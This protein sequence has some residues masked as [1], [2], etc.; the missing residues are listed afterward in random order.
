MTKDVIAL[1][2]K[3]PDP[4]A[5]LMSLYAGGPDLQAEALHAGAV[6]QLGTPAGRPLLTV[7]SPLLVHVPGEAARLLGEGADLPEAPLWWTEAR[8]TTNVPEAERLAAS[9]AGRLN[10][11]LGGATW[12]PNTASVKAVE[13]TPETA[14]L[15]A[16]DTPQPAV[17]VL[18]DKAAVVLMDRPVVPMTT[19]LAD[20]LRTAAAEDRALQIV[21]PPHAR[22]TLPTRVALG[23]HPNRWVVQD[24]E[25]G[26]YDGLSGAVLRWQHGQFAPAR[27]PDGKAHAAESF[28]RRQSLPADRQLLL[29]L[30]T[31]HTPDTDLTLGGALET[32]WQHLTG[33]PPAGWGTAEPV[34][35][36]WNPRQLTE[37]VRD[38]APEPSW[39]T[40][41]GHPDRPAL[42]TLR[43]TRTT[44]GVEEE[45][46]A[47]FGYG[48]D[49]TPPVDAL[50]SL[51]AA[52][53]AEHGL[54]S[55]LTHL[56]R[57]D[58]DLT[59]PPRLEAPPIPVSFTLGAD[60]IEQIGTDHA[61][62]PPL[63]LTPV[64]L[65]PAQRPAMHY[66][67]G[68]GSSGATWNDLQTLLSHLRP[69]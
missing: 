11:L 29:S 12:P 45:I 23:G 64:S 59:V 2:Q 65:G 68:D 38:R 44:A 48:P 63:T 46:T 30:R 8:A 32:C 50:E 21:T 27:T 39:L 49:E 62:R 61:S 1:T 52:L 51:A 5:L 14:A 66:P 16:S 47:A 42:A 35:L 28:T 19:W 67:L 69:A 6:I 18:T 31:R 4:K 57:A 58:R 3:M 53:A 56:R 36:P 26:Y 54:T 34:N 7:E 10:A 41:V 60:D 13:L 15:T 24:E 43:I 25:C 37:L 20:V 9:F 17:D 40:A 55:L 33:A 22:L